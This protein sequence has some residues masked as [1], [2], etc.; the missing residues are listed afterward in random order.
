M[1]KM[2]KEIINMKKKF[3]NKQHEM[4]VRVLKDYLEDK[5]YVVKI[6][7]DTIKYAGFK[8]DLDATKGKEKLC[9][10]VVNVKE[11]DN[12]KTRSKWE[13]ISGNRDY[14]FCLLLLEEKEKKVKELLYKW[15]I[16][17]RKLWIYSPKTL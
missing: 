10:E 9:V 6:K 13:A 17:F 16:Y 5:G 4:M 1:L 7:P 8:A 15:A 12:K 14:D 11:I 3:E 2:E